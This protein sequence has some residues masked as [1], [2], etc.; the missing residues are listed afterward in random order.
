MREG[1]N[2]DYFVLKEGGNLVYFV[3]AGGPG[4]AHGN[5]R[6]FLKKKISN[7]FISA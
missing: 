6:T 4:L 7:L 1:R 2:L 5:K 3:L